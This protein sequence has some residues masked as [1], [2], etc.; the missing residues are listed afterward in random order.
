MSFKGDEN[1]TF[2]FHPRSRRFGLQAYADIMRE[3]GKEL[4]FDVFLPVDLKSTADA[5]ELK[6]FLPGVSAEDVEIQVVNGVVTLSGEL[7]VERDAK[8][9][10]ILSELPTGKFQRVVSLPSSVDAD[11]VVATLE[12][13]VLTVLIPKAEEARSKTIKIQT[14]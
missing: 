13:G 7:K 12:N 14:K 9:D 2:Y 5:Y 8:S 3:M 6:A 1:M 4:D 10:Y 11:N